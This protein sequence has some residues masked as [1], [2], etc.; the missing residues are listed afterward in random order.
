MLRGSLNADGESLRKF[1]PWGKIIP[2]LLLFGLTF[3]LRQT[4]IL[5][6]VFYEENLHIY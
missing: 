5:S 4:L 6:L 2:T 1:N 3:Q